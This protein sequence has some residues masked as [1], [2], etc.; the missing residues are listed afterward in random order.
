MRVSYEGV[1]VSTALAG[2]LAGSVLTEMKYPEGLGGFVSDTYHA[3]NPVNIDPAQAAL[4][5]PELS[6]PV[7]QAQQTAVA[8]EGLEMFVRYIDTTGEVVGKSPTLKRG[9]G[10]ILE[11]D[12][13]RLILTAAHV[14]RG[15]PGVCTQLSVHTDTDRD[16]GSNEG[17]SSVLRHSTA[18]PY[19]RY[20]LNYND[21]LDAAALMLATPVTA[22]LDALPA[23]RPQEGVDVKPGQV[24][25]ATTYQ[26]NEQGES[27]LPKN[28][29]PL[30]RPALQAHI[31]IGETENTIT[32][33]PAGKAY[34]AL[35][36]PDTRGGS[37]G[38]QVT[39][40]ESAYLG[41]IAAVSNAVPD[42]AL[43]EKFPG[44]E[45]P[46]GVYATTTIRKITAST[47][48]AMLADAQRA[49]KCTSS[50]TEEY[51][52]HV[53]SGESLLQAWERFEKTVLPTLK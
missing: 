32:T 25:F 35:N 1:M 42:E 52:V 31:V 24:V 14:V 20:D 9:S 17:V 30:G 10:S 11:V 51:D 27:R 41:N 49:P 29:G 43:E 40:A 26:P 7:A 28:S 15:E 53:M 23:L 6:E 45:L 39:T 2:V 3:F 16:Q 18:P 50:A 38:G 34:D 8:I 12:G 4:E 13:T 37:S 33:I 19:D 21:G 48:R 44:I 22:G 47:V 46:D 5:H 36:D